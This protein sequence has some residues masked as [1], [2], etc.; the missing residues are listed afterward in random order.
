MKFKKTAG[1]SVVGSFFVLATV[2]SALLLACSN[3]FT[4]NEEG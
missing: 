1:L 4:A 2:L 3:Q